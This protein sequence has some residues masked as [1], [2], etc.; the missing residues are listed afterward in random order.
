MN[1]TDAERERLSSITMQVSLRR[2]YQLKMGSDGRGHD[3]VVTGP[4]NLTLDGQTIMNN[5]IK[6][7]N[8]NEIRQALGFPEKAFVESLKDKMERV[9]MARRA[10]EDT[11]FSRIAEEAA[12]RVLTENAS[13]D[14]TKP[15]KKKKVVGKNRAIR[16]PARDR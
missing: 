8:R 13:E 6:F 15:R 11:R 16:G 7:D 1:A 10:E 2:G 3:H 14:E 4:K 9:R 5:L 12:R